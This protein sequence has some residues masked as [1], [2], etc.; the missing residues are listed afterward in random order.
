MGK[1]TDAEKVYESLLEK[2]P[3]DKM[4]WKRKVCML[5]TVGYTDQAI[6]EMNR[7]LEVFQDDLDAWEELCDIYLN[8]QHYSQ[9]AYCYEEV[10]LAFPDNFWVILKYGEI[11]YS[12]GGPEKMVLARKYFV[13]SLILN[14]KCLRGKWL[15]LQCC[16]AINL[17]KPDQINTK[18]KEKALKLIY[19][20]YEKSKFDVKQI[21]A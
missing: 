20:A 15:L 5:R 13:E 4:T 9:A 17:V 6:N 11:L 19:K 18:L 2:N 16:N 12:I 10:V 7:Y 1:F 3:L 21:I 8:I 14:P